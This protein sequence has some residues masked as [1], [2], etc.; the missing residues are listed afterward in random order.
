MR[1]IREEDDLRAWCFACARGGIVDRRHLHL[2][3]EEAAKRYVCTEC[4]S[5]ADVLLL[6]ARA[7]QWTGADVVATFFHMSRSARKKRHDPKAEKLYAA[8]QTYLTIMH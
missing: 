8:L 5:S 2:G 6:P 4:R 1:A 3:L 7:R